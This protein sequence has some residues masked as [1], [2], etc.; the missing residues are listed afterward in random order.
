MVGIEAGLTGGETA[1][2]GELSLC[3]IKA[4][5]VV[6]PFQEV[7]ESVSHCHFAQIGRNLQRIARGM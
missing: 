4:F 7:K 2:A 5:H 1:I 6:S 3:P